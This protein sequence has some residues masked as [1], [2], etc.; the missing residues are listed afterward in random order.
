MSHFSKTTEKMLTSAF[1]YV[2]KVNINYGIKYCQNNSIHLKHFSYLKGFIKRHSTD[3]SFHSITRD[4][5]K[6][7]IF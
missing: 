6:N 5:E 2:T 3:C 7:V 1:I 4:W